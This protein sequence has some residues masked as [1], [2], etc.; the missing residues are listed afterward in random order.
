MQRVRVSAYAPLP[1]LWRTSE[2]EARACA[3]GP[4]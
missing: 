1:V 4:R 2:G 3:V